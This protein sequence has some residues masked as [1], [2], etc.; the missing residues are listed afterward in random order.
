MLDTTSGPIAYDDPGDPQAIPAFLL[1]SGAHDR[2]DWD[3]LRA[4]LP[5]RFRTIALDWPS[6]GDSPPGEGPLS[7]M[8]IADV[9]EQAVAQLAPEGALVIGNS[10]GGFAATRLAI[11]R[12]E[13]VKGLVIVD[14]GGFAGRSPLVRAFCALMA[15]RQADRLFD[16]RGGAERV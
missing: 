11:R 2:H 12:P 16:P 9:T 15:R 10:V 3:E 1:S 7:A 6:H 4:L 14:G 13:L 8:Q 5:E